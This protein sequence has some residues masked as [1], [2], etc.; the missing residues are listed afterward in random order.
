MKEGRMI[1]QLWDCKYCDTKNIL[2]RH[3]ECPNCAR[4][5]DKNIRFKTSANDRELTASEKIR[6][7]NTKILPRN[8]GSNYNY[9][10]D[11]VA[12]TISRTPNWICRYCDSQNPGTVDECKSCGA[13]RDEEILDYFENMKRQEEEKR[14]KEIRYETGRYGNEEKTSASTYER[15]NTDFK[16]TDYY[17]KNHQRHDKDKSSKLPMI[18][19][20]SS[21]VLATI[22]MIVGFIYLLKPK[23]IEITVTDIMWEY[24]INIQRYQTV[25]DSDWELPSG[26][27]LLYEQEEFTGK[28]EKVLDHTEIKT[29]EVEKQKIIGYKDNV[30]GLE[31][32]GN[33]FLVEIID[34]DNPI[35]I[36]ETYYETEEYEDLVYRKDPIY[37]TKYYY[38]IDKWLYE[39]NITT[40]AS[41]KSPYW[42]EVT[43]NSDER[44]S[45]EV[46]K[47]YIIGFDEDGNEEKILLSFDD[48]IDVEIND[49]LKIKISM[50]GKG[51]I[52]E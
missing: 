3:R 29:R 44:V 47:Y 19:M 25:E 46:E 34:D 4:P 26:A 17:Y 14:K 27:R 18:L 15:R 20:S 36:Y 21:I 50:F 7:E 28:Y 45:G 8:I 13:H 12:Q 22:L 23:T 2:A 1:E 39:R 37:A 40:S 51:E 48:W 42:G 49:V 38:E 32:L 52:V 41:D 35:P 16:D 9:V 11:D 5:R 33:G 31:D 24:V 6:Y 43:L 30:V 10:S